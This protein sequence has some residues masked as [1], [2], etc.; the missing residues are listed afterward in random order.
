ML[1]PNLFDD[2]NRYQ[3]AISRRNRTSF[4]QQS[5]MICPAIIRDRLLM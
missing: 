3:D 5:L 1:S 4:L 2:N